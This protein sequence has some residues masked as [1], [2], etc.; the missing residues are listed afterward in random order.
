MAP[1]IQWYKGL[2]GLGADGKRAP[3]KKTLE[4]LRRDTAILLGIRT[5]MA[6]PVF[7]LDQEGSMRGGCAPAQTHARPVSA[8][9]ACSQPPPH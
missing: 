8:P 4:Y 2:E 7:E 5:T 1:D 3:M 6:L 9:S